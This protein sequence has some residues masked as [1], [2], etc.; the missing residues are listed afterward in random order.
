MA[1]LTLC[2]PGFKMY[3]L[4]LTLQIRSGTQSNISATGESSQHTEG[5]QDKLHGTAELGDSVSG[6]G[7]ERGSGS[8]LQPP[9]CPQGP[10]LVLRAL[11]VAAPQGLWLKGTRGTLSTP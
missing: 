2:I 4:S 5:R 6:L 9:P 7:T 3:L 8:P 1:R 11:G 10:S